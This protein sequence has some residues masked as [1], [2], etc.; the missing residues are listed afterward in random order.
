MGPQTR[1]PPNG[2]QAH[3]L[4][5]DLEFGRPAQVGATP[6]GDGQVCSTW[7]QGGARDLPGDTSRRSEKRGTRKQENLA[8]IR[9]PC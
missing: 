9:T 7:A 4:S 1:P 3:D 2:T 6:L 8:P 5:R